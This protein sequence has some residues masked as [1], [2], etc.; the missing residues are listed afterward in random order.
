M[1]R[2]VVF[3]MLAGLPAG[4]FAGT[5]GAAPPADTPAVSNSQRPVC[6][7]PASPG[8]VRCHAHVVTDANGAPLVTAGPTGLGPSQVQSAYKLPGLNTS[9]TPTVAI[10]DAYDDPAAASDLAVFRKQFNLPACGTGCFN[11]VDQRGGTTYP[12][13]NAGWAGEI[14]LDLDAVSSAC[15][16]CHILL[17]ETDSN[18]FANLAA[19]VDTAARLGASAISNSYGGNEYSGELTDQAHFNHP[20]IA[21]TASSGDNGYGVEFPAASQYVVAVGGTSLKSATNARGWTETVWSGSGSGCS[22]YVTKPAWQSDASCSRRSVADVAAVADPYTGL[23]VYDSV[24]YQGR[25]GWQV[26]GGT[27]LASPLIA[28]VY[29]LGGNLSAPASYTYANRAALFDVSTGSN[30]SCGGGYLCTGAAGYDGPTGLGTPN[31]L[32][33]F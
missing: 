3:L 8:T 2:F 21:I 19:G 9:A 25:A 33:A 7:G 18:S 13:A 10:V 4:L 11:K 29:A 30:G 12:K 14:S 22:A 32:T 26:Y 27:S 31:G 23:S 28:S 20:N 1:R 6:P 15:P 24:R 5:A 17:V 16:T